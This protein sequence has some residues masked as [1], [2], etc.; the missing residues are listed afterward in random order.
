MN[1]ISSQNSSRFH[2][3]AV[4]GHYLPFYTDG[5]S[6]SACIQFKA[7][8]TPR[9]VTGNKHPTISDEEFETETTSNTFQHS[10]QKQMPKLPNESRY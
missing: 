2:D 10:W 7:D 8:D 6:S 4:L 5:K 1:V 9:S 3:S